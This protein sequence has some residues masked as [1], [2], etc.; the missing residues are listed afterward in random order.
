MIPAVLFILFLFQGDAIICEWMLACPA[1]CFFF[2][3]LFSPCSSPVFQ[4]TSVCFLVLLENVR[5]RLHDKDFAK[6]ANKVKDSICAF[7]KFCVHIATWWEQVLIYTILRRLLVLCMPGL[8]VVMYLYHPL[9]CAQRLSSQHGEYTQE[10][11]PRRRWQMCAWPCWRPIILSGWTL[12]RAFF[13]A[14]LQQCP[15]GLKML[16]PWALGPCHLR[17]S[18]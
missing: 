12:N 7:M 9:A 5:A 1:V 3:L 13:E 18:K 6:N 8:Q 17:F 14:F 16:W 4:R 15:C 2:L 11:K 10:Q